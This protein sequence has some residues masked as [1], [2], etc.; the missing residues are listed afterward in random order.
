MIDNKIKK[1][2]TA[3]RPPRLQ[4]SFHQDQEGSLYE[5]CQYPVQ[6]LEEESRSTRAKAAVM[7]RSGKI[8]VAGES[9]QGNAGDIFI[10]PIFPPANR[11]P[12][13]DCWFVV[14]LFWVA[15]AAIRLFLI[16]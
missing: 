1:K 6:P 11:S 10:L 16:A 12:V 8:L 14:A 15:V 5:V 3:G 9:R 2:G 13:M 7:Q 4:R